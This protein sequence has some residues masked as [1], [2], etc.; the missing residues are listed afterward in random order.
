MAHHEEGFFPA[1]DNLRLFWESHFPDVVRAHVGVVHGYGDHSGRYRPVIR[2]LVGQGF[3]VH[4]F[5]YR[6][7]GQS[8]GRRGYCDHFSQYVEDLAAFHERLLPQVGKA[9]F[10][11]FGHSTG[12]LI[13]LAWMKAAHPR[14]SGLVLSSPFFR[15]GFEP[16]RLKVFMGRLVGRVIPWMRLASE[17]GPEDLSRDEEAQRATEGDPLYNRIVTPRFF[18]EV[19]AA[20]E[21]VRASAPSL[22]APLLLLYGSEDTVAH[23]GTAKKFFEEAGSLDKQCREYAGMKHELVNELGKEEVWS[24]ISSWISAHL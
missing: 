6:G 19:L 9:P 13:A 2:H 20:Q 5:D 23:P 14:V 8:D 12:A 24:E 4:A 22:K 1:R 3:A 11:L 21:R 17:F 10:F 16:P 18:T 15:L 7:H